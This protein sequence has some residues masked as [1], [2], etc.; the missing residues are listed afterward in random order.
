[1]SQPHYILYGNEMSLYT[2]KGRSYLRKKGVRFETRSTNHPGFA[3]AAQAVGHPYQPILETPTGEFVQDTT[4]IIDFIEARHPKPAVV[5]AGPC[6]HLVA[7]LFE[8][9]GDEGLLKPAMHYRWNFPDE[10][11]AFLIQEFSRGISETEVP[12]PD[13]DDP[14]FPGR[15]RALAVVN[16]M[17][18]VM[19]PA[20]G[21]TPVSVSAI[22]AAYEELLD[23]LELHFRVHP[24]LLGGRPSVGDFGMI[25]PLYAHLGR[26]PHPANLMKRRAPM[27]YRWVERM[28]VADAAMAEFPEAR[29]AF[30]AEDAVPETLLPILGLMARDFLPELVGIVASV[31]GWLAEHPEVEAAARVPGTSSGMGAQGPFGSHTITLRGVSIELRVRHYTIWLLQRVQDHHAGLAPDD[32]ARA[33]ALLESTGLLPLYSTRPRL[34]I[35]RRDHVEYFA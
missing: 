21:V 26:D 30:L 22:E 17:R 5:P 15:A 28:N 4:E 25:A 18:S 12:L 33:D 34:R 7:L 24:Y 35:E 20:L 3:R 11:D 6:Q 29:D 27:L 32:R 31:D 13:G 16:V 8:L 1:M 19:L 14:A 10:N 2:G 9:Y 23:L